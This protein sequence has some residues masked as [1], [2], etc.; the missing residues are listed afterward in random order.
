MSK[1]YCDQNQVCSG[2]VQLPF[3]DPTD[4]YFHMDTQ[5]QKARKKTHTTN[6]DADI[7]C[8][9]GM[10]S[11]NLAP[12]LPYKFSHRLC[13]AFMAGCIRACLMCI[14]T[15]LECQMTKL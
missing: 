11:F 3:A 2:I 9:Y 15:A 14:K 1:N 8:C 10:A 12:P 6:K 13:R 5:W 4:I 7:I